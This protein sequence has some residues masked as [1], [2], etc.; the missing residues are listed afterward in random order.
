M[1][2]IIFAIILFSSTIY[3]KN[4]TAP[5]NTLAGI[6]KMDLKIGNRQFVDILIIDSAPDKGKS[7]RIKGTLSVPPLFTTKT[8]GQVK[9]N[10]ENNK[11]QLHYEIQIDEGKGMKKFEYDVDL[12]HCYLEESCHHFSGTLSEKGKIAG[13]F[14]AVRLVEISN[15]LAK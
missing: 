11:A 1:K 8:I 9:V 10:N 4:K 7:G 5:T 12:S 14:K 3:A 2:K 6:F 15:T 13:Y